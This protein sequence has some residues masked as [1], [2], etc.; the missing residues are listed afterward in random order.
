MFSGVLMAAVSSLFNILLRRHAKKILQFLASK[1][2]IKAC[3]TP[4]IPGEKKRRMPFVYKVLSD[5]KKAQRLISVRAL[6]FSAVLDAT[7]SPVNRCVFAVTH[8]Y[9]QDMNSAA[10]APAASSPSSKQ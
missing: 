4:A 2:F 6:C 8:Y 7:M 5:S 1:T 9:G 3:P 10:A